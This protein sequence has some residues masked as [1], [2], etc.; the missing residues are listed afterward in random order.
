MPNSA[1]NPSPGPSPPPPPP[2]PSLP[3]LNSLVRLEPVSQPG[4][5]FRHCYSQG[6]VTPTADSGNDHVFKLVA[7]LSGAPGAFSFQSTNFPA[8]Y[9]APMPNDASRPGIVASPAALSASWNVTAALGGGFFISSLAAGVGA[10]TAGGA[11]SGAGTSASN[12]R[13]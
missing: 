6:F 4:Y 7:A 11:L 8:S 9:I 12:V 2:P 3:P 5:A 13:K 1:A 10:L